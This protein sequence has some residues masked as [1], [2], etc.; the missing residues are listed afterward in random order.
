MPEATRCN[1]SYHRSQVDYINLRQNRRIVYKR[2]QPTAARAAAAG[3]AAEEAAAHGPVGAG[4]A[5]A[6]AQGDDSSGD[7]EGKEEGEVKYV[8]PQSSAEWVAL[9]VNP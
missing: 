4:S 2:Q 7:D 9:E 6:A 1:H 3:A 5:G 8:Q